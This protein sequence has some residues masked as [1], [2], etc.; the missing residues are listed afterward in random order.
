MEVRLIL[1]ALPLSNTYDD[2]QQSFSTIL[3][4]FIFKKKKE[5]KRNA[6]I[7]LF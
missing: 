7:A 1:Q 4:L 3:A 2:A 5:I 6:V